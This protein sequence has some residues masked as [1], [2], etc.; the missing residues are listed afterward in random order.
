M[1]NI[2]LKNYNKKRIDGEIPKDVGINKANNALVFDTDK[3]TYLS[4][5]FSVDGGDTWSFFIA[6]YLPKLGGRQSIFGRS[7]NNASITINDTGVIIL[8]DDGATNRTTTERISDSGGPIYLL[9]SGNGTTNKVY[10]GFNEL[11]LNATSNIGNL[12]T[13][14]EHYIGDVGFAQSVHPN[15]TT[16]V[17]GF[18]DGV[19]L[20]PSDWLHQDDRGVTYFKGYDGNYGDNG[21]LL[22]FN[23]PSN[24]GKDTRPLINNQTANNWTPHNFTNDDQVS[25]TW[26][27]NFC[28]L[29]HLNQ[30]VSTNLSLGGLRFTGKA[31][32]WNSSSGTIHMYTGHW[33]WEVTVG[34]TSFN[35]TTVG[36]VSPD[37]NFIGGG[38]YPGTP[39]TG[40][41]YYS[42]NGNKINGGTSVSYGQSF[43]DG[44]V[45]GVE[46]NLFTGELTFYKNGVSQGVAYSGLTG[47]FVPALGVY[48][49]GYY[50]DINFGQ[51]PFVYTAPY[52]SKTLC[53]ANLP[54]SS[55]V[56]S[57]EH[58]DIVTWTGDGTDNRFIPA[59][60]WDLVWVKNR[61]APTH[62]AIHDRLR[63]N[64]KALATNS[65]DAENVNT[66]Y[67]AFVEDGFEISYSGTSG[68]TTRWNASGDE[69]VAWCWNMGGTS[70]PNT[71]GSV[72][73]TVIM[74]KETGMSV[75]SF[76][77]PSTNGAFAIG[78]GLTKK[79]DL[80]IQK[81]LSSSGNWHTWHSGTCTTEDEYL[82]INT[83]GKRSSTS[84]VWGTNIP[85][86][87][88][89]E[90]TVGVSTD[91]NN[92]EIA[93][94]FHEVE[95]FSK[96]GTYTGNGNTNGPF[97][98]CGFT[99]RFVMIKRTDTTGNWHIRDT[100][101]DPYNPSNSWL[102]ANA[103]DAE[104]STSSSSWNV[105][106]NGFKLNGNSAATNGNGGTYV[107]AAFA[108]F[109]FGG[110]GL[111]P[112]EAR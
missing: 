94:C 55:I 56:D 9:V 31:A 8:N 97:I 65:T 42:N 66:G 71:D 25:D 18:V 98:H 89:F 1:S 108:E 37:Y 7:G 36:V 34:T 61:D 14:S 20:T 44:D 45:I 91:A 16:S 10:H 83:T 38:T 49:N 21:F 27:N 47:P 101:R 93:Y 70:N 5:T 59:G 67:F 6:F 68:A 95:G 50:S 106:S 57:S 43:T 109:S 102:L 29:N 75:V 105:Y 107:Y 58:F 82:L 19:E 60:N 111:Y 73:S 79:P 110:K 112:L 35:G 88:V 99:P 74:N 84:N 2:S 72:P 69:Y 41:A 46:L 23:D 28:V 63:G 4:R 76:T 103:T 80:I 85:N 40:Y 64:D 17:V 100:T 15:I 24:F 11:S 22:E 30:A 78:H 48:D 13:I 92:N 96:F 54:I 104:G 86:D 33:Y 39:D 3:G 52:G 77:A 12:N 26:S 87:T 62:H 90:M 81:E 53:T 51:K 32:N